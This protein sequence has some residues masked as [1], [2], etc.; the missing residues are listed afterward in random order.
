MSTLTERENKV[1]CFTFSNFAPKKSAEIF[2][3][4]LISPPEYQEI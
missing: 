4:G 3:E 2:F 1:V